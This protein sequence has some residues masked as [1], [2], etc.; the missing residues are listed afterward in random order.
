MKRRTAVACVSMINDQMSQATAKLRQSQ[1]ILWP[2]S[3]S[4]WR[5]VRV[6]SLLDEIAKHFV[7]IVLAYNHSYNADGLAPVSM[8]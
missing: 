6:C 3:M 4:L 5:R 7:A 1:R 8:L 2:G